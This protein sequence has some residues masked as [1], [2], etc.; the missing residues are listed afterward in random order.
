MQLLASLPESYDT[1]GT[2][3]EASENVPSIV[4]DRLIY[5]EKKVVDRH[6][7][8]GNDHGQALT[9]KNKSMEKRSIL[10]LL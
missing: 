6:A 9:V 10:S 1:L 8:I 3:L 2:A 4:I 7:V 5:E